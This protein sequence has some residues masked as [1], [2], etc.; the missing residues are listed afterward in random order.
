MD[1]HFTGQLLMSEQEREFFIAE[2]VMTDDSDD[3]ST[4]FD[5]LEIM[6][7]EEEYYF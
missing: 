5:P 2:G 3:G 4:E 7:R 1:G 6:L